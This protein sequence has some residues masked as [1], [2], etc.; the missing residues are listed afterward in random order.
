MTV[1]M[2]HILS[3]ANRGLLQQ[4]AWSNALL[5]FDYDGTLAPIVADPVNA[6]MRATTR[7]L[8]EEAARL[9]PCAVVSGRG[10]KDVLR[11]TRGVALAAAIGNH[12]LEPSETGARYAAEVRRWR[13]LLAALARVPGVLI[14]DKTY[15]LAIHYRR[16]REKKKARA[17]IL[18]VTASLG[19][20]RVIGGK[21][22]F[23][24]LPEGAPHK[25][26]ALERERARLGCDTAIFVGDDE[27]DEDVFAL[28]QPGRLLGIRVGTRAGSMAH[29]FLRDQREVDGLLSALVALRAGAAR[30]SAHA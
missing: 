15:S 4:F 12:G 27:T 24:V 6:R 26:I 17:A 18:A 28:D 7:R 29:Y 23:N 13:P 22:V 20:V 19:A 3:R 9:Y 25:G 2:R 21:Q 30:R 11:R 10:Q 8:L 5:A 14:E 1:G 16:S